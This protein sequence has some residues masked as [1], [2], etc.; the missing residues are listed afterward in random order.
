MT[1]EKALSHF[2][3]KLQNTWKM[4]EADLK[5]YNCLVDFVEKKQKQSLI[6]NQLFGKLYI[7]LFGE[8]VN[9]YRSTV[10]DNIPQ[11]EL[12]RQLA[13]PIKQ[14][15]Q[16]VTEKLNNIEME[17]ILKETKSLKEY[18]PM[19]YDEVAENLRVMVNGAL[20]EFN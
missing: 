5:A 9:Y 14:M 2:A 20:N 6:D 3:Y 16:E 15:V 7:Y 13:K 8:F 18:K 10:M 11:K 19:S 17:L 12:H 4:T 1:P